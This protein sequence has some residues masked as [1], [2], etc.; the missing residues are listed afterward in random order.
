[1]Q[2][3]ILALAALGGI[4]AVAHADVQVFGSPSFSSNAATRTSWLSAIGTPTPANSLDF[5]SLPLANVSGVSNI[6]PGLTITASDGFAWVADDPVLLGNS[7]PIGMKALAMKEPAT[8]TLL[9]SQGLD[10]LSLTYIDVATFSMRLYFEGGTNTLLVA[11]GS[12]S[13]GNTGRFYGVYRNDQPKIIKAEIRG[14]GNNDGWGVDNIEY[15]Q[16]VPEPGSIAALA[17]GSLVVLR[18][19]RK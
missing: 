15:S 14:V 1:M 12:G 11:T 6:N 4:A 18:R 17:V 19:R 7:N 2:N 16:A 10:Y 5:E 8:T 9:F 13:S 3:R